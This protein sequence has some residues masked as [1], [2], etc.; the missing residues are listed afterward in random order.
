M[1]YKIIAATLAVLSLYVVSLFAGEVLD[2]SSP[3]ASLLSYK[4]AIKG[5]NWNLAEKCYSE[6]FRKAFKVPI[7]DRRLFDYYTTLGFSCKTAGI[8][9]IEI[10]S[11]DMKIPMPQDTNKFTY[12]L[13][14]NGSSEVS[15]SSY[16]YEVTFRKESDGWK[17][18]GSMVSHEDFDKKYKEEI[19]AEYQG[20]ATKQ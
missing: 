19:P 3:T 5:K 10:V 2:L 16:I 18:E 8:L 9:P 20:S 7:Q 1:K 12:G 11:S 13:S 6:E 4:K 17:I 15:G 14:P